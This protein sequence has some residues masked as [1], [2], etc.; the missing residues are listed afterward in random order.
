MPKP[1][2]DPHD[3][4]LSGASHAAAADYAIALDAFNYFHGDPVGALKR[5]LTDAPRFVMAHVFK[6]Y[7]FGLATEA[8]TTK[9]A[10]GFVEEARALPITDREASH[11]A[12]LDHLL[13]G[14]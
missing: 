10:R 14:N 2:T 8:G 9:M 13:A 4:A 12:A 6:A 11:I 5:A 1:I 7:L 3:H